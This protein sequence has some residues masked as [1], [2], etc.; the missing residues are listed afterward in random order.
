MSALAEKRDV[1]PGYA[2]FDV[3]DTLISVKS[4]LR[5]QDYWY[6]VAGDT[7]GRAA[8]EADM[9]DLRRMD[10]SWEILNR[11]F[12]RHFAGRS[13]AEVEARGRDWF[14]LVEAST[15]NLFHGPVVACLRRH[16][17]AGVE[18]V[19]VSGSFPAVLRPV[20][21]RLGVRHILATTMAS[22]GG[23]YTGEILAPQTIGAGKAA[24]AADF[25]RRRGVRPEACHAYGDD[26]SDLALL[27][28]VGHPTAV[29]G[30]RG[31]EALAAQRGWRIISPS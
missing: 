22:V 26:I 25:L 5:F 1:A 20:A 15:P 6:E 2:F 3:D 24:A 16:Q 23:R 19:F 18:A 31:L 12:Y 4:L 30:G 10:A 9:A 7:A 27:E 8:Y 28:S 11:R 14:A 21:D 17:A 13:V 29:R